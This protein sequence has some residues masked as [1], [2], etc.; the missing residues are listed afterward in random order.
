MKNLENF[1]N[2]IDEAINRKLEVVLMGFV[3]GMFSR[4]FNKKKLTDMD[5]TSQA[6]FGKPHPD[7]KKLVNAGYMWEKDGKY[8]LTK[9]GL[10]LAD[11]LVKKGDLDNPNKIKLEY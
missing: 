3:S 2:N 8:G 7:W 5:D 4:V 1:L 9:K 6:K 10:K 11:E